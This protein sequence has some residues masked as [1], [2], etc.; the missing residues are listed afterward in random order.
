MNSLIKFRNFIYSFLYGINWFICPF[1]SKQIVILCYHGVSK[2][3]KWKVDVKKSEFVK[4][5]KK[6]KKKYEF[7]DILW[8]ENYLNSDQKL[9]KNTAI[10]TFDDGYKSVM[11]VSTAFSQYKITPSLF[12]L[13]DTNKVDDSEVGTKVKFLTKSDIRKLKTMGWI[14]AN[15]GATHANFSKLGKIDLKREIV[16]SKLTLEKL[17]EDSIKYF[18]YPK[19]NYNS[20]AIE[21]VGY[22]KYSLGF[23]MDDGFISRKSNKFILPRVGVDN[24]HSI[25]NFKA[26]VTPTVIFFRSI[27]KKFGVQKLFV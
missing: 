8:L 24:T 2:D 27:V 25:E 13:S 5:I 21:L 23:S 7:R 9:E 1:L 17:L 14:F 11:E 3:A 18:A 4:Q 15:H 6:K 12:V 20:N 22:A 16:D 10:I 26:T 19:G